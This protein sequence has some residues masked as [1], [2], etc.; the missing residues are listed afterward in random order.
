MPPKKRNPVNDLAMNIEARGHRHTL[1][2]WPKLWQQWKP[3]VELKWK[4]KPFSPSSKRSIPNKPGVYAFVI[5]PSVPPE[6]PI[7]VLMYIGMS[8]RPL[9]E[10]FHDY[11]REMNDPSGRPAINIMLRMY[12]GYLH[13]YCASVAEPAKTKKVEDHLIE[14]LAPPMNKQYPAKISRIIGAF[15]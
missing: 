2:L 1:L 4:G 12:D 3:P 11:L 5:Q 15:S 14:T 6:L 10:R 13:F 7:S 8:D 9:R